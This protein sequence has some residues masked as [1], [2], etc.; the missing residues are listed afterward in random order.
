[1]RPSYLDLA[2]IENE[3]SSLLGGA[4]IDLRTAGS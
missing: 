1:M 4:A 2:Q 3:L